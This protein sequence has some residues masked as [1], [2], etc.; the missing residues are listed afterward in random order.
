MEIAMTQNF[1]SAQ[2]TGSAA[3]YQTQQSALIFLQN[4]L[5]ALR[6]VRQI[7]FC[8]HLTDLYRN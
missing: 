7:Q 8:S 6:G 1:P 3:Q 2:R 4:I 5:S